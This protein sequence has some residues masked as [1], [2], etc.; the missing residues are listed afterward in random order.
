[1]PVHNEEHVSDA[2]SGYPEQVVT[3]SYLLRLYVTGST[4]ASTHVITRLKTMCAEVLKGR[5]QLEVID[6]RERPMLKQ[7]EHVVAV[8]AIAKLLPVPFRKPLGVLAGAEGN[9]FGVD[10]VVF[11]ANR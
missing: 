6:I 5:F 7:G 8:P 3:K 4:P 1:M 11:Q 9:L 2:P 10:L